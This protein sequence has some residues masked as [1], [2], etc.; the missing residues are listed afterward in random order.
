MHCYDA[1]QDANNFG[2]LMDELRSIKSDKL[3]IQEM[4]LSDETK[5]KCFED[6]EKYSADI[7]E[8]MHNAI[9]EM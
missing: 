1:K 8:R 7:K 6:L 4:E 9:D 3:T 2:S 5:Q